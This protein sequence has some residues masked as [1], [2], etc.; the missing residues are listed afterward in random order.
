M[1]PPKRRDHANPLRPHRA[2]LLPFTSKERGWCMGEQRGRAEHASRG[3]VR[4]G[5]AAGRERAARACGEGS[6]V[7]AF[8]QRAAARQ[9]T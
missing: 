6:S 2:R 5:G 1:I 3:Q 9:H 4:W 7:L 8:E